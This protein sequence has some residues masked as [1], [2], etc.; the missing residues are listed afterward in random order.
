MSGLV[1]DVSEL[2]DHPGA[3]RSIR[4]SAVVSELRGALAYVGEDEPVLLDL[5][6]DAVREGIAV[7]GTVSAMM[8]LECSR[9]LVSFDRPLELRVDELFRTG[10]GSDGYQGDDDDG[11][12]VR[13]GM[14]DLE[15]M[16]RDVVVLAIP[17]RPLHDEACRGLCATCGADRNLSD[18]G[19]T[20][21]LD[22]LRWAPLQ[23]L[24]R[25]ERSS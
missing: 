14:I 18:C 21:Q 17:T 2:L 5:E 11:Y 23:A 1:F 24:G 19:H 16:V 15:P 9:C 10:R 20:Q 8:H 25:L 7:S 22:D 4:R 3:S 12:E 6:A 13:E